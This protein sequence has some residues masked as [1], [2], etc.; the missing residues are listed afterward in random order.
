[1]TLNEDATGEIWEC[2]YEWKCKGIEEGRISLETLDAPGDADSDARES[3]KAKMLHLP[4][5][6]LCIP[7][8]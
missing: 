4:K 1:M 2:G 7:W 8:W 3:T 6:P 5:N